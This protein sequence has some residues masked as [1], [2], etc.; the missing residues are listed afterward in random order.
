M[1]KSIKYVLTSIVI[2]TIVLSLSGCRPKY[3]K[4]TDPHKYLT[5]VLQEDQTYMVTGFS[6]KYIKNVIIPNE[7]KGRPVTRISDYAFAIGQS[8]FG[9]GPFHLPIDTLII[10]EGITH[11]ANQAFRDNGISEITLPES[12]LHIGVEAFMGNGNISNLPSNLNYIGESAFRNTH[13]SGS[14]HI[15]NIHIESW[16]FSGTKITDIIFEEGITTIPNYLFYDTSELK[17]VHFPNS[18]LSIEEGAFQLTPKL[19]HIDF[20][21]NLEV[22]DRR[23][24]SDSGLVVLDFYHSLDIGA[25]AFYKNSSL[26][27]VRFHHP[28][29]T[30]DMQSFGSNQQLNNVEFNDLEIIKPEAFMG[31]SLNAMSLS[32]TNLYYQIV[33]NG[34]SKQYNDSNYLILAGSHLTNLT[35]FDYIGSHAYAGRN[36]DTLHIPNNIKTIESY[37]FSLAI[38]SNLIIDAEIIKSNAFYYAQIGETL[39]ISSKL[40]KKQS[41]YNT[42]GF[43]ILKLN[44]GVEHIEREAFAANFELEKLYLPNSLKTV[45]MAAFLQ[46]HKLKDVYYRLKEGTPADIYIGSFLIMKSNRIENNRIY[47]K[48]YD[49]FRIHV[50]PEMYNKILIAWS[51]IPQD[52]FYV[53]EGSLI[54]HIVQNNAQ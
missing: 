33:D 36:I 41:F 26:T 34:I 46:C 8:F 25:N 32:E 30:M 53:Y 54:N 31:S 38:I 40:I 22:I 15:Q 23:A 17:S 44:E 4:E 20:P 47:A 37:A 11:I 42:S 13:L 18:L 21:V 28:G 51:R 3:G 43:K 48:I 16:A 12:L 5:F 7:H 35:M 19:T 24:F 39:E 45:E 27:T 14:I 50:E 2:L 29:I 6:S 9:I 49:D 1:K 10:E 52:E